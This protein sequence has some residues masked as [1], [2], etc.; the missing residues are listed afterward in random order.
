MKRCLPSW[1]TGVNLDETQ[2]PPGIP[3]AQRR[4]SSKAPSILAEVAI[5]PLQLVNDMNTT[6]NVC[7]ETTGTETLRLEVCHHDQDTARM[8]WPGRSE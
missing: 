4:Q 7:Q 2:Q 5:P 1:L 6:Y 8:K 3:R